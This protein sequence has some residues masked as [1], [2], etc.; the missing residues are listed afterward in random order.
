MTLFGSH[1]WLANTTMVGAAQHQPLSNL[2]ATDVAL[3]YTGGGSARGTDS[4][5]YNVVAL[6]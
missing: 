4:P 6:Y 2:A 3:A 1:Y 5:I